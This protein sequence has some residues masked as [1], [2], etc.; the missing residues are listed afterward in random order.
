[1]FTTEVRYFICFLYILWERNVLGYYLVSSMTTTI[2]HRFWSLKKIEKVAS[3]TV[4]DTLPSLLLHYQFYVIC[5]HTIYS[6][7]RDSISKQ[8][9]TI[10]FIVY[11]L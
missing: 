9:V 6:L 11:L 2:I 3:P 10:V 4:V 7:E 8:S 1:M 5:F